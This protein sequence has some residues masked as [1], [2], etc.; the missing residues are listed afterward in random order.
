MG[1]SQGCLQEDVKTRCCC[2][3]TEHEECFGTSIGSGAIPDEAGGSGLVL[4]HGIRVL[5]DAPVGRVVEE[6]LVGLSSLDRQLLYLSATSSLIAVRWLLYVGACRDA[7]DANGS[8]TLHLACRAGTVAMV[9]EMMQH[10]ELLDSADVAGWTP[11]HVAAHMGRSE[12]VAQLLQAQADP[13]QVNNDGHTPVTL[14]V[15]HQS[16]QFLL[17]PTS[18]AT[19]GSTLLREDTVGIPIHV[20]PELGFVAPKAIMVC[21]NAVAGPL[22]R[23]AV[24]IFNSSPSYGLAFTVVTGLAVNYTRAMKKILRQGGASRRHAGS[25]LGSTLSVCPVVRLGVFDAIPLLGTGVVHALAL[26]F[27]AMQMPEDMQKIDRLLRGLSLVWWKKHQEAKESKDGTATPVQAK[28]LADCADEIKGFDLMQY[29]TTWE[30]LFQLMLSTVLLHWFLHGRASHSSGSSTGSYDASKK[31]DMFLK[32]WMQINRGIETSGSDIPEVVQHPIYAILTSRCFPQLLLAEPDGLQPKIEGIPCDPE[33][34]TGGGAKFDRNRVHDKLVP[35][36]PDKTTTTALLTEGTTLES[37]T[38]LLGVV[39]PRPTSSRVEMNGEDSYMIE[40]ARSIVG[41]T[42]Q[43][44]QMDASMWVSYCCGCLL[45]FSTSCN[46]APHAVADTRKLLISKVS[47]ETR[48]ITL[49]GLDPKGEA[50]DPQVCIILLLSDARWRELKF[51]E[52][53]LKMSTT[54]EVQAWETSLEKRP[55]A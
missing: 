19:V 41:H 35:L 4:V 1:A 2:A 22:M 43:V 6:R 3:P 46:E 45:L 55:L 23:V 38:Q 33:D 49:V 15:H 30:V 39:F 47:Y 51:N 20:E 37:W 24:L 42:N 40:S 32:S 12:V 29:L 44:P 5:G 18:C 25:F 8:T 11:L 36:E 21:T 34:E 17:D 14:C 26:S 10:S 28:P 7:S 27:Q 53:K 54:E 50:K 31:R 48:V 13:H 9:S 52:L 16:R